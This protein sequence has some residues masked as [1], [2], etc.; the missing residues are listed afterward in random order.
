MRYDGAGKTKAVTYG[1]QLSD[2]GSCAG[3][4][5]RIIVILQRYPVRILSFQL[6][7]AMGA[8]LAENHGDH[9]IMG[10]IFQQ[11]CCACCA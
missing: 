5:D 2:K 8:G 4:N 7:R 11:P 6:E 1:C 10:D 9:A 3:R